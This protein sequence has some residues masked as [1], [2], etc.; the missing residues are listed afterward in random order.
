MIDFWR[1]YKKAVASAGC[2]EGT[3]TPPL[4][5][6]FLRTRP[7]ITLWLL[8]SAVESVSA[9]SLDAVRSMV[10]S[11]GRALI[12]LGAFLSWEMFPLLSC[13]CQESLASF[14]LCL[15]VSELILL[16]LKETSRRSPAGEQEVVFMTG[17]V[18]G[19]RDREERMQSSIGNNRGSTDE[20]KDA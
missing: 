16:V 6:L 18:P 14:G 15:A 2:L 10:S 19:G 1:S 8:S 3:S 12:A 17:L 5:F 20:K 9:V 13:S 11:H 4:S 7:P